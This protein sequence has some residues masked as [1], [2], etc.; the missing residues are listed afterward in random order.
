[1]ER[2]A[3]EAIAKAVTATWVIAEVTAAWAEAPVPEAAAA[4]MT[5]REEETVNF[6]GIHLN[7]EAV[8]GWNL[9][10]K[11]REVLWARNI[12]LEWIWD[13]QEQEEDEER[14]R[15]L[16]LKKKKRC[17]TLLLFIIIII[18]LLLLEWR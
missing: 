18:M 3:P 14:K 15:M 9:W 7:L 1:M 5:L 10:R 6:L 17:F 13:W 8:F 4:A 12:F 11:R 16:R 2:Q